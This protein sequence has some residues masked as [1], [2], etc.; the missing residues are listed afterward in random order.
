MRSHAN[1]RPPSRNIISDPRASHTRM[2]HIYIGWSPTLRRRSHVCAHDCWWC[3]IGR[4]YLRALTQLRTLASC[5]LCSRTP[6]RSCTKWVN[7]H[8]HKRV[9]GRWGMG[10]RVDF[11]VR[12]GWCV[13][14]CMLRAQTRG[15]LT[16]AR[17]ECGVNI[18]SKQKIT[19]TH[20]ADVPN[21]F[22]R[23]QN[24]ALTRCVRAPPTIALDLIPNIGVFVFVCQI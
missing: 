20:T 8:R 11:C 19:H 7:G 1:K 22:V 23:A 24:N 5:V 13:C 17:T 18:N 16:L 10:W 15:W 6:F 9:R 2:A 12:H 4:Y 14:V 21:V 3:V